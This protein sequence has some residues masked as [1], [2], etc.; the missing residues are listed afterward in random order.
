V[1]GVLRAQDDQLRAMVKLHGGRNWK[2][3]AEDLVNKTDVQCLHRWQKVLNPELVKGPWRKEARNPSLPLPLPLPLP[4]TLPLPLARRAASCASHPRLDMPAGGRQSPRARCSARR[5]E[6][7]IHLVSSSWPDWQ[8][9][10]RA[11]RQH[12]P[13]AAGSAAHQLRTGAQLAQPPQP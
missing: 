7:V 13:G 4:L 12:C 2:K 8:A 3:I 6:V 9:V 5:K 10:P 1:L 11:V